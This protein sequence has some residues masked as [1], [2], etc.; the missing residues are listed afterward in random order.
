MP[1]VSGAL[2]VAWAGE[3]WDGGARQAY[4]DDEH[5]GEA[6]A[7]GGGVGVGEDEEGERED[8]Q[9]NEDGRHLPEARG[10]WE[11]RV[12]GPRGRAEW[13]W[14]GV[15]GLSGRRGGAWGA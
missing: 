14:E 7:A 11:G 2:G 8:H 5:P 9:R 13:E 1:G 3:G 12:G 15:G 4:R 6:R 10:K